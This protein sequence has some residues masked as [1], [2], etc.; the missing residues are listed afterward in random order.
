MRNLLIHEY[1][2]ELGIEL[3]EISLGDC[4]FLGEWTAKKFRSPDDPNYHKYGC[5][6]RPNYERAILIGSLI[7]AHKVESYLEIGFGRGLSALAAAK[8]LHERGSFGKVTSI[9]VT[10][11]QEHLNVLSQVF[12][13]EWLERIEF[14]QGLSSEVLPTLQGSTFDMT[15]IDGD[16][17]Y[18]ATR[19][20]W[21][22]SS[23]LTNKVVL[24]DDYHLPG[25]VEKD[26][27]CAAAINEIDFISEGWGEPTL[28]R[29]D[30]RIFYDDRGVTNDELLYGQVCVVKQ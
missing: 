26:I 15:Y 17:T 8:A 10:F 7:K 11:D 27:E 2:T 5:V 9:D 28:V 22:L 6:F 24:F 25:K 20:D 30:R 1:L 18:A 14:R 3:S 19:S 4:D 16:H 29:A 12:P 13:K 23:N 21:V